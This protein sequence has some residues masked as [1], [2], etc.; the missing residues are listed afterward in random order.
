MDKYSQSIIKD[1]K[2]WT[3]YLQ[4]NQSYLGCTYLWCKREDAINLPDANKEEQAELFEILKKLEKVLMEN[5]N[6]DHINYAFFGNSTKHLHCHVIP[7]Y[8]KSIEFGG[9]VFTDRAYGHIYSSDMNFVISPQT[10]VLIKEKLIDNV[11]KF[12]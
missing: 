8:S 3:L 9:V 5:F 1:Y 6:A 2:Y 11:N 4:E 12:V 10:T 7:R